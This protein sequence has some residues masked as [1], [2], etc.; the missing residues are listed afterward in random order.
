MLTVNENF[1]ISTLGFP[2]GMIVSYYPPDPTKIVAP[3][4]W[5][6]CDG[7]NG[8]PDLRGRFV[9]GHHNKDNTSEFHTFNL[10]GGNDTKKITEESL[11]PHTHAL[12]TNRFSAPWQ[13]D[14]VDNG[15]PDNS[16]YNYFK[17]SGA[18]WYRKSNQQI[19][20][21]STGPFENESQNNS[22]PYYVML[23]I[24]KIV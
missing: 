13:P 7:S 16:R 22:P 19:K 23:Y 24:M 9:V 4:G 11:P 20:T 15:A 3:Q 12:K 18:Y 5:S 21:D 8:T 1:Q 17:L 10:A 2:R 6:I 14:S